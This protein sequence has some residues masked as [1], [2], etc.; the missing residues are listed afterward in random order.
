MKNRDQINAFLAKE[1]EFEKTGHSGAVRID[2]LFTGEIYTDGT[3]IARVRDHQ[4]Q[5]HYPY[6]YQRR[7]KGQYYS[8]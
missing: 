4:I 1:T 5:L 7:D 2:G 6:H 3:L 8:R